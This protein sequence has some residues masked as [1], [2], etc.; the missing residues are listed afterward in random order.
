MVAAGVACV[1]LLII[2]SLTLGREAC[3]CLMLCWRPA[4][5]WLCSCSLSLPQHPDLIEKQRRLFSDA[6]K[7][8]ADP[9]AAAA[10][11]AAAAVAVA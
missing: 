11:T 4:P 10:V 3:C 8:Y 1:P 2:S 6:I 5:P 9:A 7:T